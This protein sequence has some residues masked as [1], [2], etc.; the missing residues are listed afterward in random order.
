[1]SNTPD[2]SEPERPIECTECRKPIKVHYTEVVDG[3]FIKTAMCNDCPVLHRKLHGIQADEQEAVS[4]LKGAGLACG[5]CGTTLESVRVGHQ[6]GC[7]ECYEVFDDILLAEMVKENRVPKRAVAKHKNRPLH[8]GR[9]P[10][11]KQELNPSLKLLALNEALDETLK[12]EDYEQA[13]L[14]RDQIKELTEETKE[15]D[16]E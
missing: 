13:A 2:E 12:S 16:G 11:E 6:L 14:L 8:I 4:G 10:G 9:A 5:N 7:S 1:M 3:R 15:E